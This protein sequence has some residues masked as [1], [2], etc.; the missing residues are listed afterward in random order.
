MCVATTID[1]KEQ[2]Y[3]LFLS[4][5]NDDKYLHDMTNYSDLRSVVKK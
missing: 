5:D 3:E 1:A 4:L 2:K